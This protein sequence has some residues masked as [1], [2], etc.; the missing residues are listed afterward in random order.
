MFVVFKPNVHLQWWLSS[1]EVPSGHIAIIL[2]REET[3]IGER[4]PM[5][6][7]AI[8]CQLVAML[9]YHCLARAYVQ[10]AAVYITQGFEHSSAAFSA[11]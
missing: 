1:L 11:L 5:L 10:R 7:L 4:R 6:H 9:Q 2:L 8:V 3:S